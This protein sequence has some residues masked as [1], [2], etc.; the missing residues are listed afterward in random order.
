MGC[1]FRGL[2]HEFCSKVSSPCFAESTRRPHP[3]GCPRLGGSFAKTAHHPAPS[4]EETLIAVR[5]KSRSRG[6][7]DVR[8]PVSRSCLL[9]D[10]MYSRTSCAGCFA[11]CFH[12]CETDLQQQ[13]GTVFPKPA[14]PQGTCAR[15]A[16]SGQGPCLQTG[17]WS[18]QV[19]MATRNTW[20][21]LQDSWERMA[22]RTGQAEWLMEY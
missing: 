22:R 8:L 21:R 17:L 6:Q 5:L 18:C 19:H 10:V 11:L 9:G 20:L 4:R 12:G 3:L 7:R 2:D 15:H 16:A 13:R 1:S 14:E